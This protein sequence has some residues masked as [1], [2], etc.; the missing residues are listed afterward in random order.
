M[1]D[2]PREKLYR[3]A[4]S[5][6]FNCYVGIDHAWQDDRGEWIF[7]CSNEG[8]GLKDHLFRAHELTK[9]CL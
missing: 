8:E 1:A 2:L 3:M 4:W 6:L 7:R 5:P 9:F